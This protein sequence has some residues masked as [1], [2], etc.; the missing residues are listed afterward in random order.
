MNIEYIYQLNIISGNQTNI[1]SWFI[2]IRSQTQGQ[3]ELCKMSEKQNIKEEEQ[4]DHDYI[5]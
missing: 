4:I 1:I 3:K 5:L 2:E